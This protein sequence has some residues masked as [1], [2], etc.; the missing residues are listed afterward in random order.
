[1]I[2]L[3]KLEHYELKKYLTKL[4]IYIKMEKIIIKFGDIEIEK[5]NFDQYKRPI[6]IKIYILIK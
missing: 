4:K 3:N 5:Q 6:S 2:S 1:M